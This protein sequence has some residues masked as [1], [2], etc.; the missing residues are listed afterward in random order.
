M[1]SKP[2]ACTIRAP[3][4]RATYDAGRSESAP[5]NSDVTGTSSP[6]ASRARVERLHEVW[7]FSILLSIALEMPTFSAI[8]PTDNPWCWRCMRTLRAI[9][10]SRS[11]SSSG[12]A[13]SRS[14][15]VPALLRSSPGS[16]A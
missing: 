2:Q 15:A 10:S 12:S 9:A 13:G 7:A 1:E 6:V 5:R 14:R 11:S 4:P 16:A 8:S 3:V